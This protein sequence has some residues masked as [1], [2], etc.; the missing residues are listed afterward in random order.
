MCFFLKKPQSFDIRTSFLAMV[1]APRPRWIILAFCAGVFLCQQQRIG[2]HDVS[3]SFAAPKKGQ[4]RGRVRVTKDDGWKIMP[5][6]FE[7]VPF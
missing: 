2:V 3:T 5:F 1:H 6:P 7:M 4:A